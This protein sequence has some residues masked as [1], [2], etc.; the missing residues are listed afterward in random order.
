MNKVTATNDDQ[1]IPMNYNSS[2][3]AE[4]QL[5]TIG[6]TSKPFSADIV[7]KD[8]QLTMEIDTGAAVS[9]ITKQTF[10]K[11]YPE[12]SL[13]PSHAILK[14]YTGERIPVLGEAK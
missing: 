4:L 10:R 13:Q 5:F 14:A 7:V 3:L 9:L 11:L 2:L 8:T 6:G 1:K 12:L